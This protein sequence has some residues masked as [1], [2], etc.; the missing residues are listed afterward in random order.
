MCRLIRRLIAIKDTIY[1]FHHY[2]WNIYKSSQEYQAFIG[3][4]DL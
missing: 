3:F 1:I 2:Q 4:Y